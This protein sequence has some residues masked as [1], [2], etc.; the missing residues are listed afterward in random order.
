MLDFFFLFLRLPF[1]LIL[2]KE[3]AEEFNGVWGGGGG[4]VS[5]GLKVLSFFFSKRWD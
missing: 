3:N 2:M 4:G 1:W 5:E